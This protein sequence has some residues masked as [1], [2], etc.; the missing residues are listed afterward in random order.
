MKIYC[1]R[2]KQSDEYKLS[3]I[4]KLMGKDLWAV[5]D[6]RIDKSV[7][8]FYIRFIRTLHDG[9]FLCYF[10]N[11]DSF[12]RGVYS[13]YEPDEI[14]GRIS[15]DVHNEFY[16]DL[17]EIE[18]DFSEIYTSQELLDMVDIIPYRI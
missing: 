3:M 11:Y 16:L 12:N 18:S 13:L 2:D 15:G 6:I 14:N 7:N 5:A 9:L 1:S 8:K 4:N 17:N 10:I